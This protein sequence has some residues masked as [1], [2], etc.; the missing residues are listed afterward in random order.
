MPL[1]SSGPLSFSEIGAAL[2]YGAPYSLR[3]MSS[4]AGF[5]TPDAVSEFYGYG[6]DY[7]FSGSP[8]SFPSSTTGYTVYSGGWYGYD[9]AYTINPIVLSTPY[10][11]DG[12]GSTNLYVSTNGFVTLDVGDGGIYY[13]PQDLSYPAMIAGNP[14]DMW[15]DAGQPLSD[16]DIQN[17][18]YQVNSLGSKSNFKL[19]IYGA[20]YGDPTGPYS[21]V[22]NFYRDSTYQWM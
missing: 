3:G 22:I 7:S 5:S 18:W 15:L 12:N 17:A 2:L 6:G 20:R 11:M 14:G 4:L 19:I 21:Y 9:D 8:I 16:G 10:Y 13:S 1:P